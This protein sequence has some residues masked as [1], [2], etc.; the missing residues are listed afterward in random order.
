MQLKALWKLQ[1]VDQSLE[2]ISK[3]A[4]QKELVA[5]LKEK[6]V[7]I[8]ENEAAIAREEGDISNLEKKAKKLEQ[9]LAGLVAQKADQERKLYDGS[10][11]SP[12]ELESMKVKLDQVKVRISQLEDQILANMDMLEDKVQLLNQ[13]TGQLTELKKAYVKGVKVYQKNKAEM[14]DAKATAEK[15]QDELKGLLGESLL[16][17]YHRIQQAFKNTG[18]ARVEKGLCSGC[19]VEIPIMY[20]KNIKESNTIYT[21]EQCGRILIYWDETDVS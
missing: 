7:K 14:T 5:S 19:R 4:K 2:K 16:N 11:N 1:E 21:C 20:L 9:E 10:T 3:Q 12:K 18:I 6:Q 15:R 8:A 13:L 17:K